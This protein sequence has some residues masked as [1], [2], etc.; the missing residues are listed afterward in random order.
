MKVYQNALDVRRLSFGGESVPGI[1]L[2]DD[3]LPSCAKLLLY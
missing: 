3:E 1:F 2:S